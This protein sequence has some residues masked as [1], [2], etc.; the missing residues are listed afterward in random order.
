MCNIPAIYS[1]EMEDTKDTNSEQIL[2]WFP[3][4]SWSVV[5][6]CNQ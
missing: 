6:V 2:D 5:Q 4:V 1:N 3:A